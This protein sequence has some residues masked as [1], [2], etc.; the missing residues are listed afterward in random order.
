M[1]HPICAPA[2]PP[3]PPPPPHESE[4]GLAALAVQAAAEVSALKQAYHAVACVRSLLQ[5]QRLRGSD[6]HISRTEAEA[7]VAVVSAEFERRMQAAKATIALMPAEAAPIRTS[8]ASSQARA[9]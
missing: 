6:G 2:R 1:V 8:S 3:N 7:I 4:G 5:T 9:R